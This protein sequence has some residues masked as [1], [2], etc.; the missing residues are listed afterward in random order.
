MDN[1]GVDRKMIGN[2]PQ[3]LELFERI[4]SLEKGFQSLVDL[5]QTCD[6]WESFP[7]QALDDAQ[8]IIDDN[9]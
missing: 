1:N 8:D 6:S 9:K 5:A 2:S 7:S 4:E 3:I